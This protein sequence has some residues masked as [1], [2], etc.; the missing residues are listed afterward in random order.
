AER[1]VPPLGP[2]APGGAGRAGRDAPRRPPRLRAPVRDPGAALRRLVRTPP[3]RAALRLPPPRHARGLRS[4]GIVPR[5]RESLGTRSVS[6]RVLVP[7]SQ[8]HVVLARPP[9]DVTRR[10]ASSS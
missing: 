7:R 2:H 8:D 6:E 10:L 9:L 4:T 1:P 5:K 3:T